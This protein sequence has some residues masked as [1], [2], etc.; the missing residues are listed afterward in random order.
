VLP[1]VRASI[2]KRSWGREAERAAFGELVGDFCA[3][4]SAALP[5][6]YSSSVCSLSVQTRERETGRETKTDRQGGRSRERQRQR[7][8]QRERDRERETERERERERGVHK[9]CKEKVR[10]GLPPEAAEDVRESSVTVVS[11]SNNTVRH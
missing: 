1:F 8:T 4:P 11:C 2:L 7:D 9:C 6:P 5:A 10:R 3:L